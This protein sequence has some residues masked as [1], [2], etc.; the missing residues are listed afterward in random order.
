MNIHSFVHRLPAEGKEFFRKD[1][2][3]ENL[4]KVYDECLQFYIKICFG[5][6]SAKT[7][8]EETLVK[9]VYTLVAMVKGKV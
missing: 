6:F 5:D 9:A 8:K 4:E 7:R 1:Y 3:Y 2:I